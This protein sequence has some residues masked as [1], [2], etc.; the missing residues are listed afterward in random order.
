MI[1]ALEKKGYIRVKRGEYIDTCLQQQNRYFIT[2][3]TKRLNMGYRNP[4][5]DVTVHYKDVEYVEH[6]ASKTV[7]L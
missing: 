6:D 5:L 2:S 3:K 7:Q 1:N 4:R